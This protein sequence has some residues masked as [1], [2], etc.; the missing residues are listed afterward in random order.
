MGDMGDMG[1]MGVTEHVVGFGLTA[2]RVLGC[3]W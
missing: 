2:R 1:D 3:L